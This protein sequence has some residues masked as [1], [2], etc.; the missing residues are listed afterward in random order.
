[1]KAEIRWFR[2]PP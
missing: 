1:V 2:F